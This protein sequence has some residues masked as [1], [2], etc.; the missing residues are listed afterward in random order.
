MKDNIPAIARVW[1]ENKKMNINSKELVIGDIVCLEAG[2][3]VPADI[4]VIKS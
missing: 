4:I 2:F 3:R 1:R